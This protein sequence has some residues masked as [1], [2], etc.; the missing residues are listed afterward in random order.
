[1]CKG[2]LLV[3]ILLLTSAVSAQALP[4]LTGSVEMD[5][6]YGPNDALVSFYITIENKGDTFCDASIYWADFW[7]YYTCNCGTN[8]LF[9]ASAPASDET[10]EFT[11]PSVLGP[12]TTWSP[13]EP[14]VLAY[15]YSNEPYRF[16]LY[17]DSLL[18]CNEGGEVADNLICGEFSVD[19]VK[20]EAD[21]EITDCTVGQD[22]ALPA[23]VLFT[24]VVRNVGAAATTV[25]TDVDFFMVDTL[26]S[27]DVGV[28]WGDVGADFAT[29][30]AD[31]MPETE[32]VV[33]STL[34]TCDAALYYPI[35]TVNGFEVFDEP[36][37]D[38]N[39]CIPEPSMYECTENI[40]LP[41]LIFS[42]VEVDQEALNLQGVIYIHGTI[43]NQGLV[44]ITAQESYKLCIYENWPQK[45][46]ECEV[47]EQG[48]NGWVLSFD[49]GLGPGL[50]QE[51]DKVSETASEGMNDYWLRVDCDC[52]NPEYGEI[53]E[54]DEKN[55]EAKLDNILIPVEGPDLMVS[56]FKALVLPIDGEN[57]IRY[58]VEVTNIG[59]EAIT[60][61]IGVDL[62]R[63]Y[64]SDVPLTFDSIMA[65][66]NA[67]EEWPENSEYFEIPDGLKA[68]G[69]HAQAM[70]SD[71][72]PAADGTYQPWVVVDIENRI[73]EA[74]DENNW[75]T[76]TPPIEY[77]LIPPTEGPNLS[78][79]T[80]T[81]KVTG[82]RITYDLLVRNAG[83]AVAAGPFRIDLF[84]D[85]E[86]PPNLFDQSDIMLS[87]E[88]LA[89]GEE[90]PWTY[91]WENV[92]DGIYRS[93]ALVDSGNLIAETEEGDNLFCFL[94]FDVGAMECPEGKILR[95][96]CMCGGEPQF[97]GYCCDGE[98]SAVACKPD[99]PEVVE[100]EDVVTGEEDL[101]TSFGGAG[102]GCGCRHHGPTSIPAGSA[103]AL[104]LL[105]VGYLALRRG[106]TSGFL[107]LDGAWRPLVGRGTSRSGR[108]TEV[109]HP[110]QDRF[111]CPPT[112]PPD[113][114]ALA[115][116]G[117]TLRPT[118][119][120]GLKTD[121]S[122]ELDEHSQS[123]PGA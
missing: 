91:V 96:G 21:L 56:V 123:E 99:L 67:E 87:V 59:T 35:F 79:E 117:V 64:T 3:V 61:Y 44:P 65:A 98:W 46:G 33:T 119:R 55:N 78:I 120:I 6:D 38:N 22:P 9:C 28:V 54:S 110:A 52:V 109:R 102:D 19:V 84:P 114:H 105:A 37:Y 25:A 86:N 43:R 70:F 92:P 71:W 63:D 72:V 101:V 83:D 18:S 12:G 11:D 48:V 115:Q 68:N 1:M 15:P 8:P 24:A 107:A 118:P 66:I 116:R 53:L 93:C 81:G 58:I 34:S 32:V 97:T 30:N 49:N 95:D 17:V 122:R 10:W 57:V 23:G 112:S 42:T 77:E 89:P 41:D 62:Y 2:P 4:N 31:L 60:G 29:V 36:D 14:V 45:P 85:Q 94:I 80:F 50:D 5:I 100:A 106:W 74:N 69:D 20:Q 104:V 88:E 76:I 39:W 27:Q 73:F 26:P 121:P 111:A 13:D 103:A 82:N 75:A 51:F 108:R 90:A 113:P 40:L 16:M 7:G 47:P